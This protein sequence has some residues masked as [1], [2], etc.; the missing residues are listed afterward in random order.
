M[1][2][3]EW[4]WHWRTLTSA[5]RRE[6]VGHGCGLATPLSQPPW[7]TLPHV[8]VLNYYTSSPQR[9]MMPH[10][11]QYLSSHLLINILWLPTLYCTCTC[12]HWLGDLL[13]SL[14]FL[15]IVLVLRRG[16]ERHRLQHM[17]LN[18]F[19]FL[20]YLPCTKLLFCSISHPTM[21]LLMSSV[22]CCVFIQEIWLCFN[23]KAVPECVITVL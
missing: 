9:L 10:F 23:F 19:I 13:I 18:S 2:T 17:L 1:R 15:H 21:L 20:N 3:L 16:R 4:R 7:G 14:N 5:P 8:S 22:F 6:D 11:S 12:A